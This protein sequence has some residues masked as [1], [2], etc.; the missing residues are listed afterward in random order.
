MFL[1]ITYYN[2]N[3]ILYYRYNRRDTKGVVGYFQNRSGD[4][5]QTQN[6]LCLHA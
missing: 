3:V 2:S 1:Y 4:L 6:S 5:E